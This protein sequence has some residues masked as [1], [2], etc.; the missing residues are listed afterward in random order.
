MKLILF[1]GI[2]GFFG[3]IARYALSSATH[4]FFGGRAAGFPVGT[5]AVNLLGCLL[6]GFAVRCLSGRFPVIR[7]LELALTVGFFGAFTTFST[8]A[9][10][11]LLLAE[12]GRYAGMI[13]NLLLSNGL[14]F[15][16]VWGGWR[17]GALM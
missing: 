10:D 3:A 12:Q 5:L 9:Y 17:L 14:G 4:A 1:I 13:L 11:T 16:A 2:G 8:Y 7:E 6:L 15:L